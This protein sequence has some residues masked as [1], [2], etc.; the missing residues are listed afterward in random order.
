MD[1][2]TTGELFP[3]LFIKIDSTYTLPNQ[4]YCRIYFP[5]IW[6]FIY[7][8]NTE[9]TVPVNIHCET[10]TC[11]NLVADLL[12]D[13]SKIH[14][15]FASVYF[16]SCRWSYVLPNNV[17]YTRNFAIRRLF[18]LPKFISLFDS[19]HS[20]RSCLLF[21]LT[22]PM[23]SISHIPIPMRFTSTTRNLF[24]S[25]Y[26]YVFSNYSSSNF[27]Y[28]LCI[29]SRISRFLKGLTSGTSISNSILGN[30]LIPFSLHIAWAEV[31][32]FW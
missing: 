27:M 6:D 31:G 9:S 19:F 11:I 29:L 7:S 32:N 26:L 14:H 2:P 22:Y 3:T 25:Y 8:Q 13:S 15:E 23:I 16:F 20:C 18:V 21:I 30:K 12:N 1:R 28:Y 24:R 5:P 4:L 10:T 17:E